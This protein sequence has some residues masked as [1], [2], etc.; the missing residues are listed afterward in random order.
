MG[1]VAVLDHPFGPFSDSALD[2]LALP[3]EGVELPR[4]LAGKV[5]SSSRLKMSMAHFAL[6]AFGIWEGKERFGE[7]RK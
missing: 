3:V 2:V 7:I 6:A 4:R 5:G 1:E